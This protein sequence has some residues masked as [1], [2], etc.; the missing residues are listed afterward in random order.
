MRRKFRI[1]RAN[2]TLLRAIV[3]PASSK[4]FLVPSAF[5]LIRNIQAFEAAPLD[6]GEGI[7]DR[8]M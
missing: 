6:K 1:S 7:F 5:V 2:D 3:I 4:A 8:R